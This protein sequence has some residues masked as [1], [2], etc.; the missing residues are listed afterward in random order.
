MHRRQ[1]Y[2]GGQHPRHSYRNPQGL[3]GYLPCMC[4][5]Y[6]AGGQHPAVTKNQ[7]FSQKSAKNEISRVSRGY[8]I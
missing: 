4:G 1:V 8:G 2:A 5:R 3:Q 7:L 6:Y